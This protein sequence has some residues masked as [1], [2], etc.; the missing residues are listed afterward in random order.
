MGKHITMKYLIAL[1]L[2]ASCALAAPPQSKAQT[3]EDV[4]AKS[5][6]CDLC[7]WLVTSLDD[8]ITDSTTESEILQFLE[9]ICSPLDSIINGLTQACVDLI[10]QYG[11]QIIED[12]VQNNLSPSIICNGIG[13]C[14]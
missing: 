11:P 7:T 10:E 12:I 5:I 13:L 2:L 4:L 3:Y 1:A 14:P 6:Q 8:F 9:G